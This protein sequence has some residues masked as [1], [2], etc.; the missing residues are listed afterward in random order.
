MEFF[1]S[2]NDIDTLQRDMERMD[3][4][5]QR[6]FMRRLSMETH[7]ALQ[8]HIE[9]EAPITRKVE[10]MHAAL[11]DPIEGLVNLRKW[12]CRIITWIGVCIGTFVSLLAGI[13]SAGHSFG[14]W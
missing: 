9:S 7:V 8:R 14:W 2:Y 12:M 5:E 4:S 6:R 3:D 13:A 10:E 11:F 1:Q